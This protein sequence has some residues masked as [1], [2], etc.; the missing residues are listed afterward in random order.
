MKSRDYNIL[1]HLK[2]EINLGT[3]KIRDR[4]KYSRKIKHKK[5]IFIGC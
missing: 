4:S 5:K 3:R 1:L 2:G